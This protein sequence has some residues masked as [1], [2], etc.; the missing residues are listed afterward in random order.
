MWVG[1]HV[2]DNYVGAWNYEIRSH[3]LR[4]ASGS[5]RTAAS[6]DSMEKS[7]LTTLPGSLVYKHIH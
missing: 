3:I 2:G 7:T 1:A 4:D 6:K 5:L